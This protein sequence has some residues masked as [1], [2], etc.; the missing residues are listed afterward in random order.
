MDTWNDFFGPLLYL[1]DPATYT[2]GYGLQQFQGAHGGHPPQLMAATALVAL[3]VVVL[4][5]FAQKTFIRGI[6]TTGGK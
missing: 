1:N 6:A 4:F 3:P 5:L 2:L